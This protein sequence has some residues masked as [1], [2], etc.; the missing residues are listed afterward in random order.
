[1]LALTD[2]GM[3]GK[4]MIELACVGAEF[5][6]RL[7]LGV[8]PLYSEKRLLLSD[9]PLPLSSNLSLYGLSSLEVPKSQMTRWPE[10]LRSTFSSFRSRWTMPCRCK[11]DSLCRKAVRM[12]MAAGRRGPHASAISATCVTV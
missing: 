6:G 5:E 4:P 3:S 7:G 2:S 8:A 12:S 9:S 10:A 11:C 1:M